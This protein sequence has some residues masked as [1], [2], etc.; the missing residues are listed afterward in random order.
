VQLS[1]VLGVGKMVTNA[2]TV[3]AFS[4]KK[5]DEKEGQQQRAGTARKAV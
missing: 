1:L 5:G 4:F 3:N 2:T